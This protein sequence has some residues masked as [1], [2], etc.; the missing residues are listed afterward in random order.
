MKAKKEEAVKPEAT[1]SKPT[2]TIAEGP[3]VATETPNT[4]TATSPTS[5]SSDLKDRRRSSF[6]GTITGRKGKSVEPKDR[7]ME[8][9]SETEAA[10][11]EGKKSNKLG[12]LFRKSSK[13]A[14]PQSSPVTDSAAPPAPL[15]DT[16]PKVADE[17][18]AP[19]A[20]EETAPATDA[21]TTTAA[22]E[23]ATAATTTATEAKTGETATEP[24]TEAP[25]STAASVAASA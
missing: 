5:G 11:A 6:F 22:E 2:E 13:S 25:A 21:T 8:S 24:T 7:K 1:T 15:K 14:K 17:A 18:A 19:A 4:A 9:T 3:A 20:T 23:P 10:D 12:G 16:E